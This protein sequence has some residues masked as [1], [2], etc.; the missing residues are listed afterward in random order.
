M[1]AD[2]N[3]KPQVGWWAF[4]CCEEDLSEIESED[5]LEDLLETETVYYFFPTREAALKELSDE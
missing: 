5:E 1:K 2:A 4:F 3:S